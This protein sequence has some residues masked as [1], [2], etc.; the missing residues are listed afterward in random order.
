MTYKQIDSSV[1]PLLRAME[2]RGVLLDVKY[3]RALADELNE[4]LQGL[5][6]KIYDAVGHQFLISSPKQLGQVLYN[7]LKLTDASQFLRNT[8]T[9]ISTAAS[10]LNKLRDLHPVVPLVLQ[11][12]ETAKLLSTYLLPL[13][14]LVG[15]DGRLHTAF[16]QDT[17]SGRLSS[18][19]PNLQNIP[20]R[21]EDGASIRR[22]FVA[23][24]GKVLVS[25]DYSQFELRIAAWFGQDKE[26]LAAFTQGRDIHQETARK[27]GVD[28]RVAKAINFG[29]IYGKGAFALG[30]ELGISQHEAQTFIDRYFGAF[31]GMRRNM[32]QILKTLHETGM[33]KTLFGRPRV[34]PELSSH[35]QTLRRA[36]ERAALNHPIQGTQ[37][38][39]IK[40]AMV[41]VEKL[42]RKFPGTL[43][44]L[45]IHDELLLETPA[46]S[47]AKLI[48]PL[49]AAMEQIEGIEI[50][51]R[52]DCKVGPNWQ[53][54]EAA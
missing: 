1:E 27:L 47:V 19:K 20:I 52:V 28:R 24:P 30:E 3:L 42:C 14:E 4:R 10:E 29:L 26:L 17:A 40:I 8:K 41:A 39:I 54:M 36:A 12:R 6:T 53:R 45:Q 5:E 25:A 49:K 11:W 38:E 34:F 13:P 18:S 31:P 46:A 23:P 43:L 51:I 37:A 9:G 35:N 15:E 44:I 21:T 33:V 2:R 50:P 32:D 22:A 7:E 48:A 16:R